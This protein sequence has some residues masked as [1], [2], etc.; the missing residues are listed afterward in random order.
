MVRFVAQALVP[1]AKVNSTP[2]TMVPHALRAVRE[3]QTVNFVPTQV[4]KPDFWVHFRVGLIWLIGTR[5]R[6][7][8][9][10]GLRWPCRP[11][12]R[13]SASKVPAP[14]PSLSAFGLPAL[15]I[16]LPGGGGCAPPAYLEEAKASSNSSVFDY[17]I[18]IPA[19]IQLQW[20]P[21]S[22]YAQDH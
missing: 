18:S 10:T 17:R 13:P 20:G 14:W 7:P 12:S 9:D 5:S 15:L 19:R 16:P 2:T 11:S 3:S 6:W 22:I 8:I 1:H 21:V 4:S